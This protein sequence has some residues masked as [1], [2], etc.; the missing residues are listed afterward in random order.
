MTLED[1]ARSIFYGMRKHRFINEHDK[2]PFDEIP[3]D[4]M[5]Q[6]LDMAEAIPKEDPGR[7]LNEFEKRCKRIGHYHA[8]N[9]IASFRAFIEREDSE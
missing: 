1:I 9:N 5:A 7:L 8:V 4:L 3:R 2:V 6:M